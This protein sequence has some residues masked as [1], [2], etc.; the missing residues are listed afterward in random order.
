[1][2]LV[3]KLHQWNL[4][5]SKQNKKVRNEFVEY[6]I[7]ATEFFLKMKLDRNSSIGLD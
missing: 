6:V 7:V 1:M 3:G 4:C 5:K 2:C